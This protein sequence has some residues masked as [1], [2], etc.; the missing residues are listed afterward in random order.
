MVKYFVIDFLDRLCG[1]IG[2]RFGC[3]LADWSFALD[4]HWHGDEWRKLLEMHESMASATRPDET[5]GE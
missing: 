5:E 3:R 4:H 1:V 2:H